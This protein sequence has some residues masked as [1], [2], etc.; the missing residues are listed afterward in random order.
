MFID[1]NLEKILITDD[2]LETIAAELS[3]ISSNIFTLCST[4]EP[5]KR[6]EGNPSEDTIQGAFYAVCGHLERIQNRLNELQMMFIRQANLQ[7]G[8][9]DS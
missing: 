7:E 9:T 4:V 2:E 1:S 6:P 3:G 8:N 5:K